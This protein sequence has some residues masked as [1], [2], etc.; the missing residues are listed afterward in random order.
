[1]TS[2]RDV[3]ARLAA[4]KPEVHGTPPPFTTVMA[5]LAHPAPPGAGLGRSHRQIVVLVVLGALT[6]AAAAWGAARLLS[7]APVPPTSVVAKPTVGIGA[8]IRSN[9]RALRFH[10]ADPAGGPPWGMRVIY[11]TRGLACLQGGRLVGGQLGAL[12]I[13]RYAFNGDGRFH[14]FLAADAL[15]PDCVTPDARGRLFVPGGPIIVTKDGLPLDGGNSF[16]RVHCDLP[17]QNDWGVR[18]PPPDLREVAFGLLGPEVASIAVHAGSRNFKVKPYGPSGAYLIVLPAPANA[19]TGN[20]GALGW[21]APGA[22][23]LTVT[24]RDGSFCRIPATNRSNGCVPKGLVYV[25]PPLPTR[26]SVAAAVHTVYRRHLTSATPA[27][28]VIGPGLI[29]S[30][31]YA[32]RNATSAFTAPPGPGLVISVRARVDAPNPFTSYNVEIQRPIVRGCFG[33]NLLLKGTDQT[34]RAG[35]TVRIT[36]P[37]QPACRGTYTGR[38]FYY[39]APKGTGSTA[40]PLG[41]AYL[42]LFMIPRR[43]RIPQPGVTVGRFEITLP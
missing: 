15:S 3:G 37:L 28:A 2:E 30:T 12:G 1:M 34:I 9:I 38:V 11:T 13:D 35:Q 8:P 36:I 43:T 7:G 19:N 40:A 10:A 31:P 17:G 5:R 26:A 18:C 21:A 42:Q 41:P 14:P 22:A 29:E 6:L 32:Q 20:Y 24:Y 25:N 16:E 39:A 23:V 4:A 27:L 33:R